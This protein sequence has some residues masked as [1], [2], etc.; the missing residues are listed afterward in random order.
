[1]PKKLKYGDPVEP[2]DINPNGAG[3]PVLRTASLVWPYCYFIKAKFLTVQKAME[4]LAWEQYLDGDLRSRF[5]Y[6]EFSRI[7]RQICSRPEYIEAVRK[8]IVNYAVQHRFCNELKTLL[9]NF[10]HDVPPEIFDPAAK[11]VK[12][13]IRLPDNMP[14]AKDFVFRKGD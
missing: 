12:V 8:A 5:S 3:R 6:N 13:G 14:S 7:S 11:E 9:E 2:D 4:G 10:R 1:M